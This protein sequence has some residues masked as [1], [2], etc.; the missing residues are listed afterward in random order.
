M[1]NRSESRVEK[2]QCRERPTAQRGC[3]AVVGD[4]FDIHSER[5]FT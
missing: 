1:C 3:I 2:A 4:A 5:S